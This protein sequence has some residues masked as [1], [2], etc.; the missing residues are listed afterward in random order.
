MTDK[1]KLVTLKAV[2]NRPPKDWDKGYELVVSF[3]YGLNEDAI[4]KIAG[5]RN[6]DTGVGP[7]S[8]KAGI[9]GTTKT[10]QRDLMFPCGTDR[11]LAHRAASHLMAADHFGALTIKISYPVEHVGKDSFTPWYGVNG[12][13]IERIKHRKLSHKVIKR[14]GMVPFSHLRSQ[15]K[16]PSHDN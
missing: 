13:F 10:L 1:I 8:K 7:I 3:V 11:E 2:N 15:L 6:Y 14:R 4:S 16:N 12:E 9:F 5:L